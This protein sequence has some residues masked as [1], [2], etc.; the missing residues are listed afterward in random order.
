MQRINKL[1][2]IFI[3]ICLMTAIGIND[4]MISVALADAPE[5]SETVKINNNVIDNS[6]L[7]VR[8]VKQID[9]EQT[10]IFK[11]KLK[12]YDNGA[13]IHMDFSDTQFAAIFIW[14]DINDEMVYIIPASAEVINDGENISADTTKIMS[15]EASDES[16]DYRIKQAI[17]KNSND[18]IIHDCTTN[19]KLDS[20]T[21]VKNTSE[22]K[23]AKLY[24]ALYNGSVLENLKIVDV[25]GNGTAGSEIVC[26]VNLPFETITENHHVRIMLWDGDNSMRPLVDPYDTNIIITDYVY[27]N[28]IQTVNQTDEY[29]FSVPA[30]GYYRISFDGNSGITASLFHSSSSE[31]SIASLTSSYMEC[32]L[33][34]DEM[35]KLK[36]TGTRMGVYNFKIERI[37]V[38]SGNV[39]QVGVG[40]DKTISHEYGIETFTFTPTQTATYNLYISSDKIYPTIKIINSSDNEIVYE[41]NLT[42]KSN[43]STGAELTANEVYTIKIKSRKDYTGDFS[44]KARMGKAVLAS[45]G[46]VNITGKF[47]TASNE[48]L[49]I[50]ALNPNGSVEYIAQAKSGA[51][52]NIST[53]VKIDQTKSGTHSIVINSANSDLGMVLDVNVGNNISEKDYDFWTETDI[54]GLSASISYSASKLTASSE[55]T[56]AAEISNTSSSEKVITVF[57][58]IYDS[59]E[60]IV[61]TSSVSDSV[62]ANSTRKIEKQKKMPDTVTGYK[63][64]TFVWLGNGNYRNSMRPI[65]ASKEIN[66]SDTTTTAAE[67]ENASM[68]DE[69][70]EEYI[71]REFT[72]NG[73]TKKLDTS[74][75]AGKLDLSG[76]ATVSNEDVEYN[77][78]GVEYSY[79][80]KHNGVYNSTILPGTNEI[81]F[82]FKNT[83]S[84]EVSFIPYVW[85]VSINNDT[86]DEKYIQLGDYITLAPGEG[87]TTPWIHSMVLEDDYNLQ[88]LYGDM[89]DLLFHMDFKGII[90]FIPYVDAIAPLVFNKAG[91]G[92]FIYCNNPEAID[93]E[94]LSDNPSTPQLLLSEKAAGEG[95]YSLMAE[96]NNQVPQEVYLDVQFFS[97]NYAKIKINALGVQ[98]PDGVSWAC[99]EAY[100]DYMQLNFAASAGYE[101]SYFSNDNAEFELNASKPTVWLSDLYESIYSKSYPTLPAKKGNYYRCVYIIVDFEIISG[102]AD[103]NIA[104]YRNR[105]SHS[106]Y[107]DEGTYYWDRMHKGISDS[108]PRVTS[109]LVLTFNDDIADGTAV[110]FKVF[111]SYNPYGYQ[112]DFWVTNLNPQSDAWVNDECAE[113]DMLDFVYNDGKKSWYFGN[114]VPESKKDY[115]WHFDTIHGDYKYPVVGKTWIGDSSNG[116]WGYN[117]STEIPSNHIPNDVLTLSPAQSNTEITSFDLACSLGNYSVQTVYNL[118]LINLGT[119][120]RRF[121]YWLNT[122]SNNM[123]YVHKDS[124]DIT[125]YFAK[126]ENNGDQRM[127]Y[128]DVAPTSVEYITIMEILP[129]GNAGGMKN[130]FIITSA[131]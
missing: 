86:L 9:G 61:E 13:W 118:V 94:K 14:D 69:I 90:R 126:G 63:W 35:Y 67:S 81:E 32:S 3:A 95:S 73:Q 31:S 53:E 57:N 89:L 79:K 16:E 74:E 77:G 46:T 10:M 121:E 129:T 59:A 58:I 2:S 34:A 11:G 4:S 130:R 36:V 33:A 99:A 112:T 104:A 64:K 70:S 43:V 116:Y 42:Y 62:K 123:I 84:K 96:H 100:S 71:E 48:R 76:S 56:S 54:S 23:S 55:I 15:V 5:Q 131:N 93:E 113:S 60:N 97:G 6:E 83:N 8:V 22:N 51:N 78:A 122:N 41:D 52:G 128:M 40:K 66:T 91:N 87:T 49:G 1:V 114:S 109:N 103:I 85:L 45:D 26:D 106:D 21:L 111:N 65:C 72:L 102:A 39:L 101:V 50:I 29:S 24:A 18:V 20:V 28:T 115:N 30:D 127:T 75:I 7:N 44:I 88:L 105:A 125:E 12:D 108:L 110:P 82:Y 38:P 37:A 119:R 117:A 107:C 19:G 17:I 124:G 68:T 27:S 25:P 92:K 80:I 47:N 120:T 98:R